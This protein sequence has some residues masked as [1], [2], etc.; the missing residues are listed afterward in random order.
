MRSTQEQEL[1]QLLEW[2]H[3][4]GRGEKKHHARIVRRVRYVKL[5][6]T[7]KNSQYCT[8]YT[9]I[10]CI[11]QAFSQLSFIRGRQTITGHNRKI[12]VES[13][14]KCLP[15]K[16]VRST[17]WDQQVPVKTPRNRDRWASV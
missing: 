14:K 16:R 1:D 10:T 15:A 13:Y 6:Q 5:G 11:K 9:A 17:L 2:R 7:D 4:V 12:L 3:I 8:Q